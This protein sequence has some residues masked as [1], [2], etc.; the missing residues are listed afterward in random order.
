MYRLAPATKSA[1]LASG[2]LSFLKLGRE[3]DGL[4]VK[5]SIEEHAKGQSKL[6]R[7]SAG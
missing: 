1:D 4:V 7:I 5:I 2:I 3:T 6:R